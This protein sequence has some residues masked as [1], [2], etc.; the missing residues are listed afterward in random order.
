VNTQVF[1]F[2]RYG[3]RKRAAEIGVTAVTFLTS[4]FGSALIDR[5]LWVAGRRR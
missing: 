5:V 4:A 1:A 3:K 2:A